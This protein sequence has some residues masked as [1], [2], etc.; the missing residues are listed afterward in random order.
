MIRARIIPATVEHAH[1]IAAMPRPAD[2][3]ELS[4]SSGATPLE[5]MLRGMDRTAEPLTAIYDGE[6]ACMFGVTPFSALGGMGAV[7]MIG[8]QVLARPGAQRDLLRLSA[9]VVAYMQDQ[10]PRLLYNFVDQRNRQAIRWLR[11]LGFTFGDPMP[12]GIEGR[13]F[14]PFSRSGVT[15]V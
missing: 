6:P 1:A 2:V 8:S 7:W 9:P 14:L 13:P 15:H 12:Y 11:W 3:A 4:A 5:A 10:Y